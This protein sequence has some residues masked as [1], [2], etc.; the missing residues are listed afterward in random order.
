ML[1]PSLLLAFLSG[2][3]Q[4]S[5]HAVLIKVKH[6]DSIVASINALNIMPEVDS[7]AG[8]CPN[9]ELTLTEYL[10]WTVK[11]SVLKKFVFVSWK[12]SK[13]PKKKYKP[14]PGD[15]I[16]TYYFNGNNL[17]KEED[18]FIDNNN[19]EQLQ[20]WYFEN[21]KLLYAAPPKNNAGERVKEIV[22]NARYTF[23]LVRYKKYRLPKKQP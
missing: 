7:T 16:H 6:I 22:S 11:D 3:S 23:D 2:H 8:Y 19:K 5:L 12:K 4:D 15:M 20:V 10:K 14:T 18:L 1:L 21:E 17:V 13:D 9:P